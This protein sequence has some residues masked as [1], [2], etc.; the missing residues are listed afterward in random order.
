MGLSL[1]VAGSSIKLF[2][3]GC[4][5]VAGVYG[6]FTVNR[7]YDGFKVFLALWHSFWCGYLDIHTTVE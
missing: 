2:F 5:V 3:L 1:G 7:K 4:V 6:A